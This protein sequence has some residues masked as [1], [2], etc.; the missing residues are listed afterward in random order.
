MYQDCYKHLTICLLNSMN[1]EPIC[2]IKVLTEKSKCASPFFNHSIHI[3][4]PSFN[5]LFRSVE[6]N[7]WVSISHKNKINCQVTD[8]FCLVGFKR[9]I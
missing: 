4:L 7:S 8:L 5:P 3:S 6:P 9:K 1:N 2:Y